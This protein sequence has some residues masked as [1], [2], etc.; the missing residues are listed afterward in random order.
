MLVAVVEGLLAGEP[1]DQAGQVVA[2]TLERLA[3]ITPVPLEP[4][5]QAVAAVALVIR[6]RRL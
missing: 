5:T 6:R 3:E 2:E 1:Q 4:L